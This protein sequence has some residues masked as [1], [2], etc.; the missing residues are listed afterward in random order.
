MPVTQQEE[1]T[2]TLDFTVVPQRLPLLPPR[3]Y[4]E[5][6]APAWTAGF[7]PCTPGWSGRGP[8]TAGIRPRE[9][10]RSGQRCRRPVTSVLWTCF[11][12]AS[13]ADLGPGGASSLPG[14]CWDGCG[15]RGTGLVLS[16]SAFGP[17]TAVQSCPALPLAV[18]SRKQRLLSAGSPLPRGR[19]RRNP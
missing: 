16:A 5:R 11:Q 17:V 18:G 13:F 3:V 9:K 2:R 6:A 7:S 8:H 10:Q 4:R 1:G 19:G 12:E 14:V 15:V